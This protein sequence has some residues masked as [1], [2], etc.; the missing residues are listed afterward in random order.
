MRMKM[1]EYKARCKR[2]QL[3]DSIFIKYKTCLKLNEFLLKSRNTYSNF[4]LPLSKI[5]A[6][7]IKTRLK[8]IKYRKTRNKNQFR[9]QNCFVRK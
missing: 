3:Y 7:A 8:G 1:V 2:V 6:M 4:Y 5:L 9:R